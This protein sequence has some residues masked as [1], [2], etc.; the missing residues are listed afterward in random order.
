MENPSSALP[1]IERNCMRFPLVGS[2]L[3]D[4]RQ[5]TL[6]NFSERFVAGPLFPTTTQL[7]PHKYFARYGRLA[8]CGQTLGPASAHSSLPHKR[9]DCRNPKHSIPRAQRPRTDSR[10]ISRTSACLKT[11]ISVILRPCRHSSPHGRPALALS[12]AARVHTAPLRRGGRHNADWHPGPWRCRA[13]ADLDGG[14][15]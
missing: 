12:A 7:A 8:R 13:P 11:R 15:L 2:G 1:A 9:C 10:N 4:S 14:A 6:V 3:R 5:L